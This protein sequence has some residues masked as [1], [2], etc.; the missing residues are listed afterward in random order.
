MPSIKE[1]VVRK[2]LPDETASMKVWPVWEKEVSEFDWVYED[3]ETCLLLEGEVTVS[4]SDG[5]V[6]F[7]A[8]DVVIFPKGLKCHWSVK[9]DVR[10]HYQF[11]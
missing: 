5:D 6:S 10:K 7:G 3:R 9:K 1:V 2:P 4:S 8:G 11:G